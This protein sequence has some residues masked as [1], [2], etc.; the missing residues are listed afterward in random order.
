MNN[1]YETKDL[2]REKDM[3]Y[4]KRV[5]HT[6]YLSLRGGNF[7]MTKDVLKTFSRHREKIEI[8]PMTRDNF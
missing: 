6:P 2:E 7:R 4:K 3:E 8:M 5:E 1:L